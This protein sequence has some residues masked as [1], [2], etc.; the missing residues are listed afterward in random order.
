MI[1][2]MVVLGCL[3][4]VLVASLVGAAA[5]YLSRRSGAS[6]PAAVLRAGAAFGATLIVVAAVAGALAAVVA[7][8]L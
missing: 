5:G 1:A 7:L 2:F 8:L 4:V 6:Y 3:L